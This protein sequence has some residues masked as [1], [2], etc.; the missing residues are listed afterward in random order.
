MYLLYLDDS[1]SASNPKEQHLVLAGVSVFERQVH[2]VSKDLSNLAAS[3]SPADPDGVEFHASE[4]FSGREPPWKA[5]SKDNR[6][7]VIKSVLGVL[8]KSHDSTR[9]FACVVHKPSFPG[10]DPMEIAFEELCNRFDLQLKRLY[11]E[12]NPQRGLIVID[13]STYETSLQKMALAFRSLGTRWGVVRNLADVPLFVDSRVCRHVQ[14]ADHVAYSVFRR[15]ESGDASYL[16]LIMNKFDS[17]R[18]SGKLHGLIHKTADTGCM[19]PACMSRRLADA[20]SVSEPAAEW[21][22]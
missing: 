4:I 9:A 20:Q 15:Y 8:A 12:K 11:N 16:D 7:Q 18:Y 1:G 5:L 10:R 22:V 6:R 13:K 14:L 17:D 21:Q 19:C 3:I 2:W